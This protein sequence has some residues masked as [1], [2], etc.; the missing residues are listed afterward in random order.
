MPIGGPT[1]A[2]GPRIVAAELFGTVV[3]IVG[4]LA[5]PRDKPK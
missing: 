1:P 4:A 5:A 2:G 3:V